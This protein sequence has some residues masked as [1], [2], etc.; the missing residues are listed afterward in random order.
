MWN[1]QQRTD[2]DPPDV[3]ITV[4]L[5]QPIA[6]AEVYEP[7]V[8]ASPLSTASNPSSLNLSLSER[9]TVVKLTPA[10]G[11]PTPPTP[12]PDPSPAPEPAPPPSPEPSP[13]PEPVP[14][15]D[16]APAPTPSEQPSPPSPA[17][18]VSPPGKKAKGGNRTKGRRH[19]VHRRGRARISVLRRAG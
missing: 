17:P 1:A 16:P 2:V 3:P 7:N 12:P 6:K 8:S 9:V 10:Q 4:Q 15:E 18:E 11:D 13:N 14:S 5:N 19:N